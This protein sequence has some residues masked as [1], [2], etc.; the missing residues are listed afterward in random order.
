MHA[1]ANDSNNTD[2]EHAIEKIAQVEKKRRSCEE[3]NRRPNL[4]NSFVIGASPRVHSMCML[5]GAHF[6]CLWYKQNT[7]EKSSVIFHQVG[8]EWNRACA[9][10]RGTMTECCPD[11]IGINIDDEERNTQSKFLPFE[12]VAKANGGEWFYEEIMP[13]NPGDS[14]WLFRSLNSFKNCAICAM[15]RT[16]PN[17]WPKQVDFVLGNEFE[18][19]GLRF[20]KWLPVTRWRE[21]NVESKSQ[22]V[23]KR[24]NEL[25]IIRVG[26]KLYFWR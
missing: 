7:N 10:G 14:R 22:S 3:G 24:Q 12:F 6:F 9:W 26:K 5:H 21:F 13:I 18:C 16:A 20:A 23:Y 8:I 25:L 11:T 1:Y 19:L 15:L 4:K 2:S 17:N